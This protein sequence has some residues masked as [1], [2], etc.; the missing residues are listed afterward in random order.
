MDGCEPSCQ[1]QETQQ[2]AAV[3]I[4]LQK[5]R[6]VNSQDIPK[7]SKT[8]PN[9][10]LTALPKPSSLAYTSHSEDVCLPP[11][12]GTRRITVFVSVRKRGTK[13]ITKNFRLL[14]ALFQAGPDPVTLDTVYETLEELKKKAEVRN[15]G[16]L[17]I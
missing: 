13:N 12:D 6:V 4:L 15:V 5:E 11:P 1:D 3:H 17:L 14:I 8:F 7:T 9:L 2:R 16:F 10:F